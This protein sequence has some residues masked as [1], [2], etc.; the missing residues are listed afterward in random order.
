[1]ADSNFHS[2][3][4]AALE[5]RLGLFLQLSAISFKEINFFMLLVRIIIPEALIIGFKAQ[6]RIL[7]WGW[8]CFLH[9]SPL[10]LGLWIRSDSGVWDKSAISCA[11]KS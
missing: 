4:C 10:G 3:R 9:S 5:R 8:G 7:N 2:P 1:M 6:M 11:F